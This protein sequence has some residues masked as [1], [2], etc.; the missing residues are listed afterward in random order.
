MPHRYEP[1]AR[2]GHESPVRDPFRS[3]RAPSVALTSRAIGAVTLVY[4]APSQQL[5]A[6]GFGAAVL[7]IAESSKATQATAA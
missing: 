1:R 7:L 4:A 5:T 3:A 6:G 2:A